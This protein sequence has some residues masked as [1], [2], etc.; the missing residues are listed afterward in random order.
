MHVPMHIT[1]SPVYSQLATVIPPA[2]QPLIPAGWRLAQHQVETYLALADPNGPE[3]VINTAMT[4]DGKSLG[5]Q[6]LSL[7]QG[8]RHPLFAMYPTNELI[9]DQALQTQ[10]TW[11]RWQQKTR[12]AELNSRV[13]DEI[14]AVDDFQR[15]GDALLA[16][17]SNSELIL[18]NPDIFHYIMHIFYVRGG[19]QGDAPDQ[20]IGRLAELFEQFTFDEFHVFETPQITSVMSALLLLRAIAPKRKRYL[21]QSATPSPLL[22]SFLEKGEFNYQMVNGSYLD[23]PA[24][25]DPS[26]WRQ[27]L[28]Q[29]ELHFAAGRVEEW[30]DENLE[31]V[32]LPFFLQN[33]PAAKGVIIV[34]SVAVA[35]RVKQRLLQAFAPYP[36]IHISENTGLTS[37]RERRESYDADILIGT[38]TVDI[39]VD[40]HIN[41]LLFESRDAGT[42]LQ[43]LGR[44]GRHG[45]YRHQGQEVS[46]ENNFVAYALLPAWTIESLF[47]GQAGAPAPLS[48][49]MSLPRTQLAQIINDAIPQPASFERYV[50]R[51]GGLQSIKILRALKNPTIRNQYSNLSEPLANSY[52]A[53][54]GVSINRLFGRY[55]ELTTTA[56]VLAEEAIA[57]RGGSYFDC[58]VLD[59]TEPNPA[60]Q[61][62]RYDLFWLIAN[63]ELAALSKAE[64]WVQAERAGMAHKEQQEPVAYFRLLGFRAK[65]AEFTIYLA[66]DLMEWGSNAFGVASQLSGICVQP[67]YAGDVPNLNSLNRIWARQIVPAFLCQR[68]SPFDLA[69]RLRL[70]QPFALYAFRSR[71]GL[72][73]SIAFGREALLLDSAAYGRAL[74][75]GGGSMIL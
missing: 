67:H 12:I 18:T 37:L 52:Q 36:E 42:F 33:R 8:W 29:S 60:E 2:L 40:F 24:Q 56:N 50:A 69:R 59:M 11:Q 35:K 53:V 49:E 57:F 61:A 4:G 6:L 21:F 54:L 44:L 64:F 70:P 63:A 48:P 3:V 22:R 43:R 74:D 32:L 13:L 73:G 34:N 9:A 68:Y 20:I 10:Q 30:L 47:H 75:C 14:M 58:G 19:K 15:R 55:K 17:M 45:V 16:R 65:R 27:I 62:K 71:D 5:G 39:G 31:K 51:W 46:F 7:Q 26:Q 25:A 28:Q 72:V 66:H 23:D 38:S 1:L 41:F